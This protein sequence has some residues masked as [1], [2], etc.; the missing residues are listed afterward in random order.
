[1]PAAVNRFLSIEGLMKQNLVVVP[2]QFRATSPLSVTTGIQRL[3][4]TLDLVVYTAPFSVTD[5]VAPQIW[6]FETVSVTADML[7]FEAI[8]SDDGGSLERVIVL[9]YIEGVNVW[10]LVELTVNGG[11]A[12]AAIPRPVGMMHYFVQAVDPSGNVA[13]A[14]DHGNFFQSTTT[15]SPPVA[16]AGPDR[17]EN[18][19]SGLNFTGVFTDPNPLDNHAFRWTVTADNGQVIPEATTQNFSFSPFDNGSYQVTFIVTDTNGASDSDTAVVTVANLPP[20][21]DAGSNQTV[22]EGQTADFVGAFTDPGS[23]DTHTTAWIVIASGGI[24]V[25][26]GSGLNFSFTPD[27]DDFFFVTFS[28]TDDDGGV[29]SSVVTLTSLN[30][31]PTVD[32][33][34]DQMAIVGEVVTFTGTFTDPGTADTHITQWQVEASNGQNVP[35]G[36]ALE[37][38]FTPNASGTYTLS[39]IVADDDN[40]GGID[41]AILT[42]EEGE[43]D[44]YMLYMPVMLKNAETATAQRPSWAWLL[45]PA[46]VLGLG[47]KRP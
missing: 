40:G 36:D 7:T 12:S 32:A 2:G 41:Y 44:T 15:N 4:N 38:S 10:Q 21:T 35:D 37:F 16:N 13:V 45:L 14:L 18:E 22:N 28:V 46:V 39:F 11:T 30:V 42:V 43:P 6:S 25:A 23:N 29:G 26:T 27:D 3:Y 33:G 8:V 31:S 34:P 47:W 24:T 20:I 17:N 5:F 9:Y 19:G 1:M